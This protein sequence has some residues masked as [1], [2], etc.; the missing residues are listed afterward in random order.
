MRS[1]G[2]GEKNK[3]KGIDITT[4]ITITNTVIKYDTII[5]EKISYIPKWRTR[6][7]TKTDT[8]PSDIDTISILK[9]YYAKYFYTDTLYIDTLGYAVIND[10]ITRNAI[11]SRDIKTNLLIPNTTITNTVYINPREFYWGVGLAGR[12]SQINYLGGELLFRSKK[13]QIYGLGLGVNQE[14]QPIIS[15]RMYWKIGK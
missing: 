11:L 9:D 15:G 5:D 2:G 3:D 12:T 10:T 6:W 7:K 4:P 8:I 1:C 14:F 13:Y